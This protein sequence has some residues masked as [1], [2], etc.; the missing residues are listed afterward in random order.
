[1][2]NPWNY[3]MENI[4]WYA[5]I[6]NISWVLFMVFALTLPL[7]M[8]SF[9]HIFPVFR[10]VQPPKS[11]RYHF[12][13]YGYLLAAALIIFGFRLIPYWIFNDKILHFLGGGMSIGLIYEYLVLNFD[14]YEDKRLFSFKSASQSRPVHL[15]ANLLFLLLFTSF[16]SVF[17]E[18]YEFV[19]KYFAGVQFDSSG[20]DTWL[21]IVN[22]IG[23]AYLS[24]TVLWIVKYGIRGERHLELVEAPA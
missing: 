19:S 8:L 18:M 20:V 17:S 9:F 13:T 10:A 14:C 12:Q 2:W 7:L 16:F 6:Y 15:V 21:D 24:Y 4:S 5:P 1:M 3:L 11:W 23:G 22:N